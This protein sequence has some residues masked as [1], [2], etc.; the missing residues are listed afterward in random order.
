MDNENKIE[1]KYK[2]IINDLKETL[3][4]NSVN[5]NATQNKNKNDDKKSNKNKATHNEVTEKEK[6]SNLNKS[7]S[8]VIKFKDQISQFQTFLVNKFSQE[9]KIPSKFQQLTNMIEN[10]NKEILDKNSI[11]ETLHEKLI[12]NEDNYNKELKV[13]EVSLNYLLKNIIQELDKNFQD[14]LYQ[15]DKNEKTIILKKNVKIFIYNYRKKLII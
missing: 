6:D 12:L 14:L 9:A 15:S 2:N 13:R 5:D 10:L 3:I 4:K 7:E 1:T 11:I 8:L